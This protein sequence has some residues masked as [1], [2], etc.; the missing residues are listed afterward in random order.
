MFGLS[1]FG[2]KSDAGLSMDEAI[3][4]AGDGTLTLIDV[5]EA[6]EVNAS[7]K[8]KGAI[9][10]PLMLI[11]MQADPRSPECRSD[12]SL[13]KPIGVYCASGARSQMALQA[14]K[15]CGYQSV[16]NLGGLRDW[17]AAG[18]EVTR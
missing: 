9:H 2:R 12:L 15:A 14:L 1:G 4:Q 16:H 7:G 10:I 13:E 5:R 8:A 3:R 11:Q 18:G 6:A 17:V